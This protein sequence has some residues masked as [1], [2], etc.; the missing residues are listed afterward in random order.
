[1]KFKAISRSEEAHTRERRGDPLRLTRNPAEELHPLARQREYVRAL[2]AAKLRNVFAKPLVGHLEGHR[3]AVFALG[4][5]PRSI[6]AFVSGAADGEVR[7]WDLAFQRSL[8]SAPA[9]RGIVRGVSVTHDGASFLSCGD[10]KTIKRFLFSPD[11]ALKRKKDEDDE[12][13]SEG[14]KLE[15][16]RFGRKGKKRPLTKRLPNESDLEKVEPIETYSCAYGVNGIDC[17]WNDSRF[18]SCGECVDVWDS[19]RLEPIHS[20]TWGA[21]SIKSVRFNPAEHNLL[22][23]T[24]SDRSIT[25]YDVRQGTPLRKVALAMKTN[26][27]QWN[28][29]EPLNFIAACEDHNVHAFDMRKLD[30]AL[31]IHKDHVAAVLD[32]S[33]SPTGKEFATASY[34]RTVRLFKVNEGR[35]YQMYFTKRMQRVFSVLFSRDAKFV[36]SGSDDTNLRIW[37]ADASSSL[38]KLLPRERQAREYN[39]K[40][41]ERYKHVREVNRIVRYKRT[42][43]LIKSMT[44]RERIKRDAKRRK[45][46]RVLKHNPNALKPEPER[47]RNI[48]HETE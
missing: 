25:L 42:P 16:P 9:H 44:E 6:K 27:I 20:F 3:D 15:S 2:N 14:G 46:E 10:D 29:M 5:N 34:D 30:Q 26:A 32:V 33:F 13:R 24:G 40:L 12:D 19:Q 37:K 22:G 23:S 4:M 17:N 11:A 47:R 31:A 8:W 18:A 7:V 35:S 48:I 1:M 45:T 21:E 39:A 28:P 38:T 36:V 43:K 41:I